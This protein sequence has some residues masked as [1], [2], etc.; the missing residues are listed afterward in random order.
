MKLLGGNPFLW[1]AFQSNVLCDRAWTS[2]D[3]SQCFK[4]MTEE[5]SK[6]W[7]F[8]LP[9][10]NLN[11]R[12]SHEV[13]EI[14]SAVKP[15]GNTDGYEITKDI[16]DISST[17][18]STV[19]STKPKLIPI[20]QS[21]LK[22]E[23]ENVI[24]TA[25]DGQQQ[26]NVILYTNQNDFNPDKIKSSLLKCGVKKEDIFCH[27]FDSNNTKQEMKTFLLNPNGVLICQDELF[28]GMEAHAITYCC[29]DRDYDK[30]IRCHLMRA[31]SDLNIIYSFNKDYNEHIDFGTA[32]ILPQF[33]KCNNIMKSFAVKCL[34]CKN[35]IMICKSCSI[36][37]HRGH[38][39]KF[40]NVIN[41][42]CECALNT[43]NCIF[44]K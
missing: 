1:I 26:M 42:K 44:S 19:T 17:Q 6:N 18:K 21:D 30:N 35:D 16:I 27:S 14:A 2:P 32:N 34:T 9:T 5:L 12:N 15:E 13:G 20:E 8:F 28:I 29:R 24:K 38:E 7:G 25:I 33:I 43:S 23:F 31:T 4:T 39:V 3:F 40:M 22:N 41:A 36:G 37:C 10:L 11:M